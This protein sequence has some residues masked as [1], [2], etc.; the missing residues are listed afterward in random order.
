M[1][2]TT[3]RRGLSTELRHSFD[4]SIQ[5]PFWTANKTDGVQKVSRFVHSI[6]I[7]HKFKVLS[8]LKG[9]N[10]A[11][12]STLYRPST[13]IQFSV[14]IEIYLSK[15]K[16]KYPAFINVLSMQ[17]KSRLISNIKILYF[18]LNDGCWCDINSN[19]LCN[20]RKCNY[21]SHFLFYFTEGNV[22][23]FMV[24]IAKLLIHTSSS[25]L[26]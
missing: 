8:L 22:M 20:N 25:E 3:H 15:Y 17:R 2:V 24:A 1:C 7:V 16:I 18:T 4:V 5:M 10:F 9:I 12:I 11:F 21:I 6:M 14:S 23:K 13:V 19:S 26:V